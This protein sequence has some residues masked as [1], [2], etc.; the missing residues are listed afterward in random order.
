MVG[1]ALLPLRG[2]PLPGLQR[3]VL[4]MSLQNEPS[5][6][7]NDFLDHHGQHSSLEA[8][9]RIQNLQGSKKKTSWSTPIMISS[10]QKEFNFNLGQKKL[11]NF[12][13]KRFNQKL[14]S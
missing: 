11:K 6:F 5:S 1:I 10:N 7:Q 9:E 14:W 13:Q 3:C 2:L 8:A 4:A 12:S